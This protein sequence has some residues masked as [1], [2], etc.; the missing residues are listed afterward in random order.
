M[1][2]LVP[3]Y[4]ARTKHPTDRQI[5]L[6]MPNPQAVGGACQMMQA[7]AAQQ[8]CSAVTEVRLHHPQVPS[9][10]P[11]RRIEEAG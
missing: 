3:T 4:C 6:S 8:L 7:L 5:K 1:P 9:I 10:Q 11:G 2:E